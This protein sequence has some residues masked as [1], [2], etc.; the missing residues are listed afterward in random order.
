MP[1]AMSSRERGTCVLF[2]VQIIAAS[3]RSEEDRRVEM[4]E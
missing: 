2:G 4:E 1:A 3:G